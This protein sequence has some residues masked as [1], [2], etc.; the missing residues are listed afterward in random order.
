MITLNELGYEKVNTKEASI[1]KVYR[2]KM[3]DNNYVEIQIDTATCTCIKYYVKDGE[4]ILTFI[5][6]SER[7]A[8]QSIFKKVKRL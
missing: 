4:K 6:D 8:I 3:K 7:K 2:A 5:S 1:V